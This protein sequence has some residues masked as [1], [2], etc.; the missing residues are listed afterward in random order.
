MLRNE[1]R[2]MRIEAEQHNNPSSFAK[3]AKINRQII[4]KEQQL[5]KLENDEQKQ[6]VSGYFYI[7][8]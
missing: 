3:Y 1:I 5:E 6:Q 4:K 8:V 2:K 7:I